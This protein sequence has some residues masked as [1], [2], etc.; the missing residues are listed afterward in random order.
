MLWASGV[1]V[2]AEDAGA[3][4]LEVLKLGGKA[5]APLTP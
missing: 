5:P 3:M 2:V 1:Q 4:A